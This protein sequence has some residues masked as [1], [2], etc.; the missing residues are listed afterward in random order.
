MGGRQYHNGSPQLGYAFAVRPIRCSFRA[1][2]PPRHRDLP[3]LQAG[4]I[5]VCDRYVAS[6]YG[7][8]RMDG[9][10]VEYIDALNADADVSDLAVILTGEPGVTAR[11]IKSASAAHT[12]DSKPASP[13]AEPMP[14]TTAT[15][16]SGSPYA[17]THCPPSTPPTHRRTTSRQSSPDESSS[18]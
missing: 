10:P 8:Q 7:L 3:R 5:V 18:S 15:P 12:A 16:Q 2:P 14:S 1:L 13:P 4:R 11:R 6:A 9:V 17:D